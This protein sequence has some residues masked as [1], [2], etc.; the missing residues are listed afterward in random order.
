MRNSPNGCHAFCV[1]SSS[2]HRVNDRLASVA[3]GDSARGLV[4][5]GAVVKGVCTIVVDLITDFTFSEGRDDVQ[6]STVCVR[7]FRVLGC[8]FKFSIA[9]ATEFRLELP[10]AGVEGIK[11]FMHYLTNLAQFGCV[12][13]PEEDEEGGA[14]ESEGEQASSNPPTCGHPGVLLG[15]PGLFYWGLEEGGGMGGTFLGSDS[16][17]TSSCGSH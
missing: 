13:H 12:P 6:L 5:A 14:G 17:A 15:K 2:L 16:P 7:I 11:V 1:D 8:H 9:E 10:K 3:R 4:I